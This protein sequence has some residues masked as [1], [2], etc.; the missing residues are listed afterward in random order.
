[1]PW[2]KTRKVLRS[3]MCESMR[4]RVDVHVTSYRAID[5]GCGRAWFT[6][7]G[8]E[9]AGV[10]DCDYCRETIAAKRED[11]KPDYAGIVTRHEFFGAIGSYLRQP[12]EDSLASDN[13]WV[14]A[15]AALDRRVGKRRLTKLVVRDDLPKPAQTLLRERAHV[16]GIDSRMNQ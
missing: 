5:A 6:L 11:R 4:K 9:I 15:F 8:E 16:L 14:L 7:D 13:P 3:F 12:I 1:M 2:S 10:F